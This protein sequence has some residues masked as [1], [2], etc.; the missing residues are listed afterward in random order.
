MRWLL[1]FPVRASLL[2]LLRSRRLRGLRR[3][4]L[5]ALAAAR[6]SRTSRTSRTAGAAAAIPLGQLLQPGHEPYRCDDGVG[7]GMGDRAPLLI[8]DEVA[9]VAPHRQLRADG[10]HGQAAAVA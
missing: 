3:G 4:A 8:P 6:T 7:R 9:A 10:E 1:V 2:V 5:V